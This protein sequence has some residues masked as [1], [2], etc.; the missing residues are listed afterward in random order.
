[1]GTKSLLTR[2]VGV[3]LAA[4]VACLLLGA[5]PAAAAPRQKLASPEAWSSAERD[6]EGEVRIVVVQREGAPA[7]RAAERLA[8][9]GVGRVTR[10]FH[11]IGGDVVTVRP[12]R[13]AEA[14]VELEADPDVEAAAPDSRDQRAVGQFVPWGVARIHADPASRGTRSGAGV[15]VAVIDTGIWADA[16]G[17]VHPDLAAAYRGGYDFVNDDPYPWD[18][19]GHGTHVAGIIAAQDNGIGVVGV[20]PG[21]S[22]YALKVL[23]D[24]GSGYYSDF[25]AALDWCIVNGVRIAN[26]SAGGPA[27]WEPMEVA[28]DRARAAGITIVAAAGNDSG[29]PVIYPAAYPSVIAVGSTDFNDNLSY[30][31][32]VGAAL[33]LVAPGQPIRSTYLGGGYV[34]MMGTSMATPHVT[35]AA[36]LL[37]SRRIT[38]PEVVRDY[39]EATAADLGPAGFDTSYGNGRVDAGATLPAMTM[40]APAAGAALASGSDTAVSWDPVPGA[41]SYRVLFERAASAAWSEIAA[42]TAGTSTPWRAPVV[43]PPLTTGRVQ[44]AAYDGAGRLLGVATRSGFTVESLRITAPAP[45][46]TVVAGSL[47]ALRWAVYA[48]PWPVAAITV[49][50][51]GD[52]GKT[53]TRRANLGPSAR[54]AWWRAPVVAANTRMRLRASLLD[55]AGAVIVSRAVVVVVTPAGP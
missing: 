44:V 25:I 27:P 37:A 43:G 55:G 2:P 24:Q 50:V 23:D 7:E 15:K 5:A 47:L 39:L 36:A 17:A 31:S 4:A 35:G 53:W 8:R 46:A 51:S 42:S 1:M 12:E 28:C 13:L 33:D 30:F 38:D 20:A 18:G 11:R 54:A 45:G 10:T 21:V 22:L 3:A 49:D 52:D 26:Y 14:L 9:R 29:G 32:N 40:L 34:S 19:F 48:T 41:A 16:G 6:G